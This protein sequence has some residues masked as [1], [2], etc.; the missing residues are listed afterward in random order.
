MTSRCQAQSFARGAAGLAPRG[1]GTIPLRVEADGRQAA[2]PGP[3]FFGRYRV[4]HEIG[5]GATAAVHLARLEGPSGFRR[6]VAVKALHPHLQG[7]QRLE[8]AFAVAIRR[9]ARLVH[10]NVAA[11]L[12]LGQERGDQGTTVQ[13]VACEYIH[14]EDLGALRAA[15]ATSGRA[16]PYAIAAYLV[17]EAADGLHAA[18]ELRTREGD[19]A[20]FVH[21]GLRP[22]SIVVGYDGLVKV[23]DLTGPRVAAEAAHTPPS[24]LGPI[25]SYRAPEVVRGEGEDRR[26][27]VFALGAIL[28][29]LLVGRSLYEGQGDLDVVTRAQEGDIPPLRERAPEVPE[30][31][32]AVVAKAVSPLPEDRYPTARELARALG[33]AVVAE[34]RGAHADDVAAFLEDL[35]GPRK[36]ARTNELSQAEEATEIFQRPALREALEAQAAKGPT[37]SQPPARLTHGSVAGARLTHG[38]VAGRV[39]GSRVT[40]GS[41]AGRVSGARLTHGSVAGVRLEPPPPSAAGSV[42]GARP[43]AGRI[44]VTRVVPKGTLTGNAS[45]SGSFPASRAAPTLLPPPISGP[46]TPLPLSP[47]ST[48]PPGGLFAVPEGAVPPSSDEPAMLSLPKPT[49]SL[50]MLPPAPDSPVDV[51][52]MAVGPLKPLAAP[53]IMPPRA[54]QPTMPPVASGTYGVRSR[55]DAT[56]ALK[57]PA[58]WPRVVTAFAIGAAAA[59]VLF[60]AG[61]TFLETRIEVT[62]PVRPFAASVPAEPTAQAPSA[63]HRASEPTPASPAPPVVSFEDLPVAPA[64]PGPKAT[65]GT[66]TPAA[67]APPA[68]APAPAPSAPT[69]A[70]GGEGTLT[71]VCNPACDDVLVD[72]QSVGPSPLFKHS[73]KA[74][75]HRLILKTMEPAMAKTVDVTVRDGEPAVIRQTMEP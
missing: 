19:P 65:Q 63:P 18:H 23:V 14:G 56:I 5:A 6:W 7:D 45:G 28:W 74:G 24:G 47:A 55:A 12:E 11:V 41:V 53:R 49:P 44:V 46:T 75:P 13:W 60:V 1:N 3:R 52:A 9:A 10:P 39:A 67:K 62:P 36:R 70:A 16:I 73:L 42:P 48:Y 57:Q 61:R 64:P 58:A 27:D 29:E 54:E 50:A 66:W 31:V 40:H 22:E 69:L 59:A 30:G 26:A 71:V 32:A 4:F 8:G 37:S 72:G 20:G 38:S 33:A 68:A 25:L 21:G 15:A 17:A 35:V 51:A 2:F 43:S 34:T